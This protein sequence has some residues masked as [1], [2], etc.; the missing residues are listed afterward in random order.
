MHS[1]MVANLAWMVTNCCVEGGLYGWAQTW[2]CYWILEQVSDFIN[3]EDS[4]LMLLDEN[5]HIIHYVWK[6]I[7][8]GSNGNPWW[9]NK[10]LM[11]QLRFSRLLIPTAKPFLFTISLPLMHL[12]LTMLLKHLTWTNL[13]VA[14]TMW[15]HYFWFKPR[16]LILISN[17]INDHCCWKAKGLAGHSWGMCLWSCM[18]QGQMQTSLPIWTQGLLHGQAP[19]SAGWLCAP[20]VHVGDTYQGCWPWVYFSVQVSL[21]AEPNQDGECNLVKILSNLTK[22]SFQY[23][24]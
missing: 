6:I 23:W 4:W 16:S 5:G 2:R 20:R 13:M 19:L 11:D 18:A 21:W 10:Q 3:E 8:P 15:N 12:Y 1:M 9:D 22:T 7:H 17:T 24:G 14:Q